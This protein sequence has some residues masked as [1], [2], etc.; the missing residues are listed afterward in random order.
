MK[1]AIPSFV[2][3]VFASIT[4]ADAIASAPANLE[5]MPGWSSMTKIIF[6]ISRSLSYAGSTCNGSCSSLM[7]ISAI[8]FWVGVSKTSQ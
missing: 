7:I 8:S 2:V 6:V 3:N 1:F 4:L 5:K